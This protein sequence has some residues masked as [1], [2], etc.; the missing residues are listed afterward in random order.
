MMK[1][2][3]GVCYIQYPTD[4]VVSAFTKKVHAYN[5][6]QRINNSRDQNPFPQP[7]LANKAMCQEIR[8]YSYH[9]FFKQAVI[10]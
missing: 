5:K 1:P 7:V 4:K 6:E 3:I 10:I 9:Y 2:G 8:L